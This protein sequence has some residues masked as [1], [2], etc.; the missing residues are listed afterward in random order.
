[1]YER[2]TE[3]ARHVVVVAYQEAKLM[4]HEHI[5][6]EHVLV[7]LAEEPEVAA[8]GLTPERARAE[9]VR[10]V[11][12]GEVDYEGLE[13]DTQDDLAQIPLTAAVDAALKEALGE[14]MRLGHEQIEPGH[15]LLAVLRQRDGVARRI[16]VAAGAV[17]SE[18]R[19]AVIRRLSTPGAPA[20]DAVVVRLGDDVVGDLGHARVDAR[21][22]LAIL[23]RNG[24]MAAWLRERGVDEPTLRRMLE[25]A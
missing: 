17:P 8:L 24:P 21:L 2:F 18:F 25:G 3:A 9:V 11:G 20:S 13:A 5:G 15:L 19:E 4:R 16:L 1:M 10:T 14:A 12:L 22:L 23:E 6:T 7:G